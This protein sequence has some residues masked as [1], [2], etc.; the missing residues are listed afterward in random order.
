[1]FV[2]VRKSR[3]FGTANSG[4]LRRTS[5]DSALVG[6]HPGE[7]V[8]R[9][10]ALFYP[11]PGPLLPHGLKGFTRDDSSVTKFVSAQNTQVVGYSEKM[12]RLALI[13]VVSL[14]ASC[15]SVASEGTD[16]ADSKV[17][18]SK[19]ADSKVAD[20]KV[21]DSNSPV[22]NFTDVEDTFGGSGFLAWGE[23]WSP[24]L[25]SSK[26]QDWSAFPNANLSS[27]GQFNLE[28]IT[29]KEIDKI[30]KTDLT[31]ILQLEFSDWALGD[32]VRSDSLRSYEGLEYL[33]C[34]QWLRLGWKPLGRDFR[35]LSE[36][37]ELRYLNLEGSWFSQAEQLLAL[38]KLETISLPPSFRSLNDLV[39]IP[40]LKR[41]S[42]V[43]N[44]G[45]CDAEPVLELPHLEVLLMKD[46][47][48]D[49]SIKP[50][51]EET[52]FKLSRD[53]TGQFIQ[54]LQKGGSETLNKDFDTEEV[55]GIHDDGYL[56]SLGQA[57]YEV[58]ADDYDVIA[59][60]GND[61]TTLSEFAGISVQISNDVAGLGQPI[62]SSASC[63]GS[64]GRLR[65]IVSFPTMDNVLNVWP[66]G[67]TDSS[68]T[69]EL[70][71]LWGGADLLPIQE[72]LNGEVIGGHWGVS[73][74]DGYLGGF[75]SNSLKV[76]IDGSYKAYPFSG[77]GNSGLDRPLGHLEK[78]MMGILPASEVPDTTVFRGVSP[79]SANESPGTCADD[80]SFDWT[81]STCF[82]AEERTS[83]SIEDI[84]E[85]FG[86][87]PYEGAIE[88]SVLVVAVSESP[89]TSDEWSRLD[90]VTSWNMKSS[91]IDGPN[92][93]MW[94]ASG[95]KIVLNSPTP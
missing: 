66:D 20:S 70:L 12:R 10:P 59:F 35:F 19:V 32:H 50:L 16:V 48:A 57:I 65:G 18:D 2:A 8:G 9:S 83:V 42:A 31:S 58:V 22:V 94:E 81:F 55:S 49:K 44:K 14:L 80:G 7:H 11:F 46:S 45:S 79:V 52:N 73:S 76:G 28:L 34:L 71:H 23:N 67:F 56:F 54:L 77:I 27:R 69:H 24:D 4:E 38:Q 29:G 68:F 17:A 3:Q 88:I 93:N 87:R 78:Y 75:S 86:E 43:D 47:F 1:M 63:Y 74:V 6:E 25:S 26:C 62:W 40:S 53:P 64:A 30:T 13:L 95:G 41:I 5:A 85:I 82:R 51:A 84:I 21:A 37:K 61:Q 90:K 39:A 72:R 91:P 60:V 89:L 36:L 15:S 33:T 92:Q